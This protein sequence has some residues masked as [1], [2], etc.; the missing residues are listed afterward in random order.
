LCLGIIAEIAESSSNRCQEQSG[1]DDF[2]I[3]EERRIKL[4]LNKEVT[5]EFKDEVA[6]HMSTQEGEIKKNRHTSV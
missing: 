1:Q 3:R 2:I 5:R 4:T 6:Q